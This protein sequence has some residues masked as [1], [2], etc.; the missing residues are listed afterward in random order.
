MRPKMHDPRLWTIV[1]LKGGDHGCM[2][3]DK[4]YFVYNTKDQFTWGLTHVN[5]ASP[6]MKAKF[7]LLNLKKPSRYA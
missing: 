6:N 1:L 4:N 3:Q 2:I 7:H 5:L